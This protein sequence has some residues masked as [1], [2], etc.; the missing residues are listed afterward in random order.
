[1]AVRG[2][3]GRDFDCRKIGAE[4]ELGNIAAFGYFNPEG[5][6]GAFFRVVFLKPF[7]QFA[8]FD[9]ND[10]V[11]LWVEIGGP[12]ENLNPEHQFFDAVG[13][14]RQGL[15]HNVGEEAP[16]ACGSNERA[17]SQDRLQLLPYHLR[18]WS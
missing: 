17:A 6:R 1:M 11:H 7:A 10:R 14:A 16:S 8:G 2:R 3:R 4:L 5:S 9:P 13:L 12:V 15:L 18:R